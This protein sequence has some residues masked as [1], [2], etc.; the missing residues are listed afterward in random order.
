FFVFVF[1]CH[2]RATLSSWSGGAEG[3]TGPPAR[4]GCAPAA[5]ART[6]APAP[7]TRC[8]S[9]A[10]RRRRAARPLQ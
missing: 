3:Y 2:P 1:A 5:C 10:P 4:R 9:A 8:S 6:S 7:R